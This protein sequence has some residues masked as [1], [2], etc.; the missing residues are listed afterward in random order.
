MFQKRGRSNELLKLAKIF[1]FWQ[2]MERKIMVTTLDKFGRMVI[3]KKMRERLRIKPN[4]NLHIEEE[5]GRIIIE[6]IEE[7]KVLVKKNG[8]LV[9]TGKLDEQK[10][11]SLLGDE[12]NERMEKLLPIKK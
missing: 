10:A 3:P 4:T 1:V 5:Q 9:F 8:I 7:N 11:D 12:R 2:K 6:P